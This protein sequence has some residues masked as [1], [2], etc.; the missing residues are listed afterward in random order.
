[1]YTWNIGINYWYIKIDL[2]KE[3]M[4]VDFVLFTYYKLI[5]CTHQLINMYICCSYNN[6]CQP[7]AAWHLTMK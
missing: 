3:F 5:L 7:P 2:A 4:V 1:M 6:S